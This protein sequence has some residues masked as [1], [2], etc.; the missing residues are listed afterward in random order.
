MFENIFGN[1]SIK[2]ILKQSI[3]SNKVS[4]SYLMIGVSG[5]G[6]KMIATEFAKGILC[7][8]EDKACN[9][10]KSCIEF[11]SNNNPDFFCIE[12]EGNSIKIE[13]IRELQKK[14]Q[15]KPIIS[16]KKV[17]IIDQADLMT[18]EAQNCLLK[19]LEEPPEY[20]IIILVTNNKEGLLP[21]IRSRCEIVKFTPIPFIEIKNYLINQGIEPNRANLLSSFSRGSMKKALEL[22]SSNEF[23]EMK[24]NVQKYI[25]TI[26]SKNMVE[27]L[28]IP[29]QIEQYKGEIINVLDMMINYFRD[30]MIC[31]EH[32]NKSMIINADK[33]V[34][35]Q[36]MSSKITYSQVSKIIDIIEDTKIKIKVSLYFYSLL[37]VS[38][39]KFSFTPLSISSIRSSSSFSSIISSHSSSSSS[40]AILT[41]ASPTIS[42][43]NSFSIS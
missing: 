19:T 15:E 10:C 32:V 2:N 18:K 39:I 40:T 21:T 25:E 11:N 22:A 34:F 24:E 12:P 26:L 20:A 38:L 17:Y 35:I 8:S 43:P 9:H 30:I 27:I 33:L 16:E 1:N 6:K 36:N 31:K 28:D 23:Y 29:T 13:Q 4:H 41:F 7:L 5:I 14:I 37:S 42:I 3:D